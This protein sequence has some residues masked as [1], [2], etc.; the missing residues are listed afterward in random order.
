MNRLHR[1][2]CSWAFQETLLMQ[3]GMMERENCSSSV[4]QPDLLS[5]SFTV[6]LSERY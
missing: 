6:D 4:W 3:S 2:Q 1:E 5:E